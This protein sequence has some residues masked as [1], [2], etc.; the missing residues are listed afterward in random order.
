MC[1]RWPRVSSLGTRPRRRRLAV[2]RSQVSEARFAQLR[3][4]RLGFPFTPDVI[5][6][7]IKKKI[8]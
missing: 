8:I 6:P 1:C 2:A 3:I 7:N 5:Y 4:K